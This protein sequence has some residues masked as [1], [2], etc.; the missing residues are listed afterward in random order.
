[1]LN[2]STMKKVKLK[3]DNSGL[4]YYNLLEPSEV[5]IDANHLVFKLYG[6]KT[7]KYIDESGVSA[8]TSGYWIIK[9]R[10]DNNRFEGLLHL[11]DDENI[12]LV[13]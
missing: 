13:K 12:D 9:R 2:E 3:T 5:S 11:E 7:I 10:I 6:D 4:Y 1:M 8:S